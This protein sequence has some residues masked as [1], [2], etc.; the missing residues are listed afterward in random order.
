MFDLSHCKKFER[1]ILHE[2]I[3]VCMLLTRKLL[4][5]DF[6]IPPPVVMWPGIGLG[7]MLRAHCGP[8]TGSW[9]VLGLYNEHWF[10]KAS[11]GRRPVIFG[12]QKAAEKKWCMHKCFHRDIAMRSLSFC[13]WD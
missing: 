13:S 1:N 9:N 7:P 5:Y 3:F 8:V 2:Y 11:T 4:R 6:K 12:S 10:T